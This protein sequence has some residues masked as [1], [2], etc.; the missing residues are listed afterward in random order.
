M[1]VLEGHKHEKRFLETK[2]FR[3]R[4]LVI[5]KLPYQQTRGHPMPSCDD[6]RTPL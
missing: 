3:R 5:Q 6:S 2:G 4:V 1:V